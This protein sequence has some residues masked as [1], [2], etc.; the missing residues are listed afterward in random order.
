MCKE[1]E[2]LA[3]ANIT[4][5]I[6]LVYILLIWYFSVMVA[7]ILNIIIFDS[8]VHCFHVQTRRLEIG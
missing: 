5:K 6:S 2:L 7:I 4:Q 1:L 8:C 3:N